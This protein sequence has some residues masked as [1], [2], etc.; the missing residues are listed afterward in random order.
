MIISLAALADPRV[1]H[2]HRGVATGF[3]GIHLAS[4]MAGGG[5]GGGAGDTVHE[6]IV[7]RP[8]GC[9]GR[10]GWGKTAWVRA[11]IV[12]FLK[13]RDAAVVVEEQ[14]RRAHGLSVLVESEGTFEEGIF[15]IDKEVHRNGVQP[16]GAG[17]LQ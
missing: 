12:H 7:T 5:G 14:R 17:N 3:A 16:L 13:R 15:S 9:H 10:G 11:K 8:R 4:S 2:G 1:H 6:R